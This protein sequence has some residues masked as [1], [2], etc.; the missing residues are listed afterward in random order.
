MT[1]DEAVFSIL[2]SLGVPYG[3]YND[4]DLLIG[5]VQGSEPLGVRQL[6]L[7]DRDLIEHMNGYTEWCATL[8]GYLADFQD[9]VRRCEEELGRLLNDSFV[10]SS[11]KRL[12]EKRA[13]AKSSPEV[14]IIED[15]LSIYLRV[16]S[17]IEKSLDKTHRRYM[18]LSR[19]VEVHK[20]EVGRYQ[21]LANAEKA[22]DPKVPQF[23]SASGRVF[24]QKGS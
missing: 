22:P 1:S 5:F 15:K 11:A 24:R 18:N 16:V 12:A 7:S 2:D 17:F 3:Q 23:V 13:Q 14:Q 19:R 8:C 21:R 6:D 10:S 9:K 4:A 20:A